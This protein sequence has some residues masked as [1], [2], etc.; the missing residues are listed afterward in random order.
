MHSS[1]RFPQDKLIIG[2]DLNLLRVALAIH[3]AGNVSQAAGLLGLSQPATSLALRRL[4]ESV[5]DEVFVR[6]G[7]GMAATP[8]GAQIVQA[9]EAISEI[10]E[11]T[12]LRQDVFS[13]MT[14]ARTFTIALSDVGEMVFL[15]KIT[16]KVV[17]VAPNC[18]LV[19]RNVNTRDLDEALFSGAVDL[20]LGYFPDLERSG[21]FVQGLFRHH[22]VGLCRKGHP[23]LEDGTLSLEAFL[24]ALHVAVSPPS[25]SQELLEAHLARHALKRRTGLTVSHF[26]SVPVMLEHS[27][28]IAVVPWAIA[29]YFVAFDRVEMFDLP[30]DLGEYLLKQHWHERYNLDSGNR[31]LRSLIAAEFGSNL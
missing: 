6:S 30:I 12:I 31:W 14:A 20:A 24:E 11:S 13:P 22:F 8:R 17:S 21:Y 10:V 29:E 3:M 25:R 26:L 28:L 1:G 5:G 18:S 15:P 27:D 23:L 16:S 4:R 19:S 9:A 7:Q 2:L